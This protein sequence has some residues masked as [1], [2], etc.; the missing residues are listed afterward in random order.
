MI[1]YPKDTKKESDR[2]R[3]MDGREKMFIQIRVQK[4]LCTKNGGIM[5]IMTNICFT[6]YREA[7][8]SCPQAQE[9]INF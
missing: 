5:K 9:N 3:Q 7:D 1:N 8:L 2:I 4:W 6:K